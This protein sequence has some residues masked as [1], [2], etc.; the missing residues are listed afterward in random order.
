MHRAPSSSPSLSPS[1]LHRALPRLVQ[2]LVLCEMPYFNEA[3][4]DKQ[5]GT[6]EGAH[7]AR[8]YNEGALLLSCKAMMT[9][10]QHLAPPFER[11]I[12]LHFVS[13][14]QR[15]LARCRKLLELK[16]GPEAEAMLADSGATATAEDAPAAAA[17]ATD[18]PSNVVRSEGVQRLAA[19][20]TEGGGGEGADRRKGPVEEA[21]LAGV[22]NEM[23]SLGFLH[24]LDR[25]LPALSRNLQGVQLDA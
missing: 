2:G 9:S 5:L 10:L 12:R 25:Q 8:R 23:P 20:N 13:A 22:L 11:L 21:E 6:S 1:T 19:G 18:E 17:H 4:Y 24:S 14:R 15:I 7:H 16:D 3:G